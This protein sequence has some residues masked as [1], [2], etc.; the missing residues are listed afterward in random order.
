MTN[1]K[2]A[3]APKSPAQRKAAQRERQK[4]AG[5][6]KVEF[7]VTPEMAEKLKAFAGI[8]SVSSRK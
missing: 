5:L 3:K 8:I 7:Y 1:E 4:A 6:V 2:G